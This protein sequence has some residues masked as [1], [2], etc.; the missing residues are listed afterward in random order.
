MLN[1][2]QQ[3]RGDAGAKSITH[4]MICI[5]EKLMGLNLDSSEVT[6]SN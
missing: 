1:L 2:L 6:A 4:L 5:A 3:A